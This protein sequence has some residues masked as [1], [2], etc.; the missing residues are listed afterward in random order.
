MA[1]VTKVKDLPPLGAIEV[2]DTFVGERV[3]GSTSLITYTPKPITGTAG[4]ITVTNGDQVAGNPTIT[5][6]PTY[7]GQNSIATVGTI[8]S[9]TWH[10]SP[11]DVTYG[12]SGRASATSYAPIVGGTTGTGAHQSTTNGNSGQLFQSAGNSAIPSWTTATYPSTSDTAGKM[13][14][15][16]GTNFVSSTSTY[17]TTSV[18]SGK[19]LQSDGTNIVASTATWPTA[20]TGSK[21]V[22]GDGT[23]Y[24]ESTS[25]F[26]S[27]AGATANKFLKTNAGNYVL[28]TSTISDTPGTAGKI[29][30]SDGTN[31]TTSVPTFPNASATSG[32]IIKSDGTNFVA[33]TETYAAPGT[34]GN[35]MQSN[36]TNW[37]SSTPTGSGSPVLATGP[38]LSS[39]I[40]TTPN[41]GT[42]SSGNLSNCTSLPLN[43][44]N[45]ATVSGN[46]LIANGTNWVSTAPVWV[47]ISS[48]TASS[49]ASITF[50]SLTSTYRAYLILLNGVIPATTSTALRLTFNADV[51]AV[52]YAYYG[53]VISSGATNTPYGSY[54][55]NAYFQL[56]DATVSNVSSFGINGKVLFYSPNSAS[57]VGAGTFENEYLSSTASTIK[58]TNGGFVITTGVGITSLTFAMSSGNIA[59]GTFTLWGLVA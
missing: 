7:A 46:T 31:W 32:K 50:S 9:G 16:D 52:D 11:V 1:T 30:Q 18:T 5:V 22:I 24:V 56:T 12:G 3:A 59:S 54:G 55:S 43:S 38:S 40:L 4:Y 47:K 14:Q 28:S 25:L 13:L 19:I 48:S 29:L 53:N 8:T 44:L 58:G 49:S 39:P 33:S 57:P 41:I 17:P 2:G 35:V 10:G 20:A 26:P 45:G 36:G 27:S 21:L 51:T 15:S 42:P 23:N 6:D 34:S 37:A